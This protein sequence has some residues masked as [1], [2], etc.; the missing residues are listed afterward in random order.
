[1]TVP[2]CST[3]DDTEA[4]MAGNEPDHAG[5]HWRVSASLGPDGE[6]LER[7]AFRNLNGQ[8]VNAVCKHVA[9]MTNL[10]PDNDHLPA[11]IRCRIAIGT[12]LADRLGDR[13]PLD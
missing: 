3:G 4:D 7:H 13:R 1:M 10:L 6:V 12:D 5:V 2:T 8:L 11:C 9:S